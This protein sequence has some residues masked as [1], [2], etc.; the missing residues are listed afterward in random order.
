[1]KKAIPDDHL[2]LDR[3]SE[4]E[5]SAPDTDAEKALN[6]L[7]G[8]AYC[9]ACRIEE[10]LADKKIPDA[11]KLQLVNIVLERVYGKP[12][13]ML[14]I[15]S[16]ENEMEKSS[17]RIRAF[18]GRI[19]DQESKTLEHSGKSTSDSDGEASEINDS[20][21]NEQDSDVKKGHSNFDTRNKTEEG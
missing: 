8:L 14:K 4:I 16:S 3:K 20:T 19:Q 21:R 5:P 15:Q 2:I 9:A 6:R 12:D 18:A 7:R 13:E 1:M 10:I 11:A 17:D